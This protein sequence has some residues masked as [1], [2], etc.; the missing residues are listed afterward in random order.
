MSSSKIK[1]IISCLVLA[2]LLLIVGWYE[3]RLGQIEE[4][5]KTELRMKNKYIDKVLAD[6][7]EMEKEIQTHKLNRSRPLQ[8]DMNSEEFLKVLADYLARDGRC[9]VRI[10]KIDWSTWA[11]NH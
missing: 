1:T 8:D 9:V 6:A 2:S 5:F 4:N 11:E 7:V 10:E 3:I